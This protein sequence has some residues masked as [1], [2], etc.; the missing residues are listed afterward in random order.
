MG[1]R[2][3]KI[4]MLRFKHRSIYLQDEN[5]YCI[6]FFLKEEYYNYFFLETLFLHIKKL[7][8]LTLAPWEKELFKRWD[9]L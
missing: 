8:F 3:V 1:H 5:S 6:F 9:E 4:F 2:R 7:H